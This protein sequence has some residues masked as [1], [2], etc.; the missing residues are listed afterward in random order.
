MALVRRT[1][2]GQTRDHIEGWDVADA[3]SKDGWEPQ[4][5]RKAAVAASSRPE[6]KVEVD[7]GAEPNHGS[8]WEKPDLALLGTGRRP[9]PVFPLSLLGSYWAEWVEAKAKAA[10]GP[11]CGSQ[12]GLSRLGHMV[13]GSSEVRC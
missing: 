7:V 3:L 11:N 8:S 1:P 4:A 10:S 12:H 2:D 6:P 13:S 5:L 9:A